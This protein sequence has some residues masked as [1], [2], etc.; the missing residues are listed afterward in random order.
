MEERF[1]RPELREAG[2]TGTIGLATFLPDPATVRRRLAEVS[3]GEAD[4]VLADFRAAVAD[5]AFD[6]AAFEKYEGFLR[7]MLS[8][9]E[10]PTLADLVRYPGLARSVLPSSTFAASRAGAASAP[11]AALPSEAITLI[12]LDRPVDQREA[13]A[14]VVT[15][16]R[17]ALAELGGGA[18][19]TGLPVLGHDAERHVRTEIPRVFAV[20]LGLVLLYVL[21]HFRSVRDALLSMSMVAYS[22]V[23]LLAVTR[24]AGVRLNMINLTALPLLIGMTLDY[25]IFLVSLARDARRRGAPRDALIGDVA[26]SAQ[27]VLVCAASTVLGFG[28]LAF[29]SVPAVQSLGIVVAVGMVASLFGTLF[30]LAPVLL[31]ASR[32]EPVPAPGDAPGRSEA[33]SRLERVAE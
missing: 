5:S 30:L 14:A 3:P 7:S 20:S 17:A 32:G 10:A 2:A 22:L 16:A 31:G 26:T 15:A 8:R 28:S 12:L 6:A 11:A 29:N 27:A 21:A 33:G 1:R 13:R 18:T 24:L 19:L 4:R 23:L 25:G 9:R